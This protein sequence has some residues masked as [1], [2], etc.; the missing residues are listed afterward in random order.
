[1]EA[2]R[3]TVKKLEGKTIEKQLKSGKIYK[4]KGNNC[5][6]QRGVFGRAAV[7]KGGSLKGDP[8]K[9]LRKMREKEMKL[10]ERNWSL[11]RVNLEEHPLCFNWKKDVVYYYGSKNHTPDLPAIDIKK[12]KKR[13]VSARTV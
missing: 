3:A 11:K 12:E 7:L 2:V 6:Y 13:D 8:K 9:A 1:M 5:E 4:S 10:S